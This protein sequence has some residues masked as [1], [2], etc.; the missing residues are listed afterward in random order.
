MT[1][2]FGRAIHK[3]S[4]ELQ[5]KLSYSCELSCFKY[6]T[7][8]LLNIQLLFYFFPILVQT[9]NCCGRY[10]F[11]LRVCYPLVLCNNALF[12][13]KQSVPLTWERCNILHVSTQQILTGHFIDNRTGALIIFQQLSTLT[14]LCNSQYV[15]MVCVESCHSRSEWD[16]QKCLK[17]KYRNVLHPMPIFY[18]WT[19]AQYKRKEYMRYMRFSV[20]FCCIL[21]IYTYFSTPCRVVRNCKMS[22]F[23]L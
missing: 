6:Y 14:S 22:F 19:E 12:V 10:K 11:T 15:I 4:P 2:I 18:I 1:T 8:L 9:I 7:K 20:T 3:K 23:P 21:N 13:N 17:T 16:K 5:S